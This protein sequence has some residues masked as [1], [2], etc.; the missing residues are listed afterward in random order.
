MMYIEDP[1][2]PPAR[3]TQE[4]VAEGRRRQARISALGSQPIR[5]LLSRRM[6]AAIRVTS[7]NVQHAGQGVSIQQTPEY[8]ELLETLWKADEDLVEQIREELK[9]GQA[10]WLL[11]PQRRR[12]RLRRSW[13]L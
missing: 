1:N 12:L 7:W 8:Q 2:N 3:T 11:R 9:T 4:D 13:A 5:D 10:Q 6:N